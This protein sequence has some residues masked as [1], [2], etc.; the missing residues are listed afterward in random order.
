MLLIA[1]LVSA[2]YIDRVLDASYNV[3]APSL[4]HVG[5]LKDPKVLRPE[6]GRVVLG[7]LIVEGL[8]PQIILS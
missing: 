4:I 3:N 6:E 1:I 8:C 2:E 5:G 7:F